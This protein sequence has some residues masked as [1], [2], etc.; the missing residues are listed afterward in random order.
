MYPVRRALL[1]RS[2]RSKFAKWRN[3]RLKLPVYLAAAESAA[4]PSVFDSKG[5]AQKAPNLIRMTI[6]VVEKISG[7]D[8][9]ARVFGQWPSF[10][11]AEILRAVLVRRPSFTSLDLELT[12]HVLAQNSAAHTLV[13]LRFG[14]VELD[15]FAGFNHQNVIDDLAITREETSV[16]RFAVDIPANNGWT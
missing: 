5:I 6:D 7:H 4:Q 3:E 13:T 8:K 9:V 14:K 15:H 2:R 16:S 12:V 1:S 11:D 10:H